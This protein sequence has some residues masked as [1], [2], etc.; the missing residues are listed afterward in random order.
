MS[1]IYFSVSSLIHSFWAPQLDPRTSAPHTM[2]RSSTYRSK[3]SLQNST[4]PYWK[5]PQQ[6]G[7]NTAIIHNNVQG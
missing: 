5:C 1:P 4:K 7:H 6:T 3:I 2:P